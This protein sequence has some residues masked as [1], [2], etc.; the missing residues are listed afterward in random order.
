M[1]RRSTTLVLVV[2]LNCVPLSISGPAT[3]VKAAEL[4]VR[5]YNRGKIAS[6]ILSHAQNNAGRIFRQAGIELRWVDC[7]APRTKCTQ[8]PQCCEDEFPARIRLTLMPRSMLSAQSLSDDVFGVVVPTGILVFSD[9]TEGFARWY[10]VSE[11]EILGMVISHELGH[12][13]LG[14][15]HTSVGLMTAHLD[16]DKIL[17]FA[18]GRL[19]FTPEQAS[20]MRSH[21]RE[22]TKR[23]HRDTGSG[24]STT[25]LRIDVCAA[26]SRQFWLNAG[27]ARNSDSNVGRALRQIRW[28]RTGSAESFGMYVRGYQPFQRKLR[29]SNFGISEIWVVSVSSL[30][31]SYA[32]HIE[33]FGRPRGTSSACDKQADCGIAAQVI[34]LAMARR[35][36]GAS[37]RAIKVDP[38]E[39]L[40]IE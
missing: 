33:K 7:M 39:A 28:S 22:M 6:S 35:A 9:Q 13:L 15:S 29:R 36:L 17:S 25:E 19:R 30:L 20:F 21:L 5:V 1:S 31:G 38:V 14:A 40:R 23:E 18:E 27:L 3:H 34:K 11:S 26:M 12:A 32:K 16:E 4:E 10:K 24:Q 37:R 8:H 2:T